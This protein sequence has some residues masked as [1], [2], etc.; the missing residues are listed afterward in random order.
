MKYKKCFFPIL[1]V[2]LLHLSYTI[3]FPDKQHL[4]TTTKAT[5]LEKKI[6]T[7]S[8]YIITIKKSTDS[9]SAP[10]I[11]RIDNENVWNLIIQGNDYLLTYDASDLNN[12]YLIQ[13]Q[14]LDSSI[15]K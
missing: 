1:V 5:I 6:D 4:I 7:D 9:N 14:Y 11:I 2:V 10:L 13:I 12:C 15:S 3:F 8:N